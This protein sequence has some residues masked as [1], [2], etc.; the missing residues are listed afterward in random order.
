MIKFYVPNEKYRPTRSYE[1]SAGFDLYTV[2]EHVLDSFQPYRLPTGVYVEIPTGYVGLLRERSGAHNKKVQLL[3][4]TIESD[5]RGE[6]FVVV[7]WYQPQSSGRQY[8]HFPD[9]RFT[10]KD[11]DRFA[12]L[13]VVKKE[14]DHEFVDSLE[15]LSTTE[16]GTGGFGSTGR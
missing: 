7:K 10:V 8:W 5:Y 12:Q 4:G 15:Q 6:I 1:D 11:M 2:G 9:E 13:V 14:T 3:A 16:R